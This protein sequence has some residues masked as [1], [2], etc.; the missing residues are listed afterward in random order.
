MD[1]EVAQ[2]GELLRGQV[3]QRLA[4]AGPATGVIQMQPAHFDHGSAS[5]GFAPQ[6][7][8]D[9]GVQLFQ[10]ERLDEVVVGTVVEPADTIVERVPCGQHQDLGAR[11]IARAEIAGDGSPVHVGQVEIQRHEVVFVDG[12]LLHG[13]APVVGDIDGVALPPQ[14]GGESG[15]QIDFVFDDEDAHETSPGCER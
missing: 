6:E 7:G 13:V 8:T 12:Q 10:L 3:E 14:T 5:P 15:G 9:T 11:R 2:Q 1:H 4:V